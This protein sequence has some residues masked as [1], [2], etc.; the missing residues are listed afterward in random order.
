MCSYCFVT[1]IFAVEK[2]LIDETRSPYVLLSLL[3]IFNICLLSTQKNRQTDRRQLTQLYLI[4][5]IPTTTAA[6]E[7]KGRLSGSI[8]YSCKTCC[9]VKLLDVPEKVLRTEQRIVGFRPGSLMER[10]GSSGILRQRNIMASPIVRHYEYVSFSQGI[11][12]LVPWQR[13]RHRE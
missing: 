1:D 6:A 9:D 2:V 7:L 10:Q 3:N 11:V 5:S 13:G 4:H 12:L 8:R